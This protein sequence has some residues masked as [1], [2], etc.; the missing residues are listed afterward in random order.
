MD[1]K[2]EE[3]MGD[4]NI[5]QNLQDKKETNKP[6]SPI[7]LKTALTGQQV[8]LTGA[9]CNHQPKKSTDSEEEKA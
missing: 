5:W 4:K 3:Y 8:I 2:N 9:D 7:V 6:N 1:P